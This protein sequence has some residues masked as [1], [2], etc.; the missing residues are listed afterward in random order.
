MYN[1]HDYQPVDSHIVS[2]YTGFLMYIFLTAL[3]V[4]NSIVP[5][6]SFQ[7]NTLK[8]ELVLGTIR[9]VFAVATGVF[10]WLAHRFL[11]KKFN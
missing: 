7:P 11:N 6:F 8:A 9:L 10:I 5:L 2:Q 1:P 3:N 4:F